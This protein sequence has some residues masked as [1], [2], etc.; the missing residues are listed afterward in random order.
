MVAVTEPA[1]GYLLYQDLAPWWP[2]ISPPGEYARDAALAAEQLRSGSIPVREVLE[3]G[4]GGGHLASQLAGSLELTLVDVSPEMLAV[5]RRLNPGCAHVRGDM[6]TVRLGCRFDGVL[7]HDAADYLTSESD[8]GRAARTA[9]AH[10]RPG[11][12]AVFMPDHVPETFQPGTERG[13]GSAEGRAAHFIGRK[14]DP[15]PSD[16]WLLAEYTFWLRTADGAE[17]VVQ[18]THRLGLF[19][20]GTWVRTLTEAGFDAE[21]VSGP[22]PPAELGPA[23]PPSAANSGDTLAR[24]AHP[25]RP[26]DRRRRRAALADPPRPLIVGRRPGT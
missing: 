1:A 10:C 16:T 12:V 20:L 7:M 14:Y 13:G 3:L 15:D 22:E 23:R 26:L 9:F 5:S 21:V 25:G 4:S 24:V 2:L 6:R 19:S 18:E 17:Q 11:G 8:L